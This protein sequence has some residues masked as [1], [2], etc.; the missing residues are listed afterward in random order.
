MIPR[1]P[2]LDNS[3]RNLTLNNLVSQIVM[4][5]SGAKPVMLGAN[6]AARLGL[7]K[8]TLVKAPYQIVSA[9]ETVE[10]VLGMSAEPFRFVFCTGSLSD[11][12]EIQATVLVSKAHDYDVLL[13]QDVLYEVGAIIDSWAGKHGIILS[14]M[15]MGHGWPEHH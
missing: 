3:R 11:T 9:T 14:I 5:D 10:S 2:C 15:R 7:T 6:F 4:V 13:G 12:V 8:S 1:F